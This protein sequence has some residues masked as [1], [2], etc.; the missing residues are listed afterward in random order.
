[1]PP[2]VGRDNSQPNSRSLHA[3]GSQNTGP[4]PSLHPVVVVNNVTPS[5]GRKYFQSSYHMTGA[6]P[7]IVKEA[8]C[9][10]HILAN[11]KKLFLLTE[12]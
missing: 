8:I 11:L 5:L 4:S 2:L 3:P 7:G 12:D 10:T 9:N 6:L 1:M